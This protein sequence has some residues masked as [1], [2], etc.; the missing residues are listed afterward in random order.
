MEDKNYVVVDFETNGFQ[1]SDVLSVAA[2]KDTGEEFVRHYYPEGEYNESAIAVNGLTEEKITELRGD[3]DY[4]EHFKDDKEFVEF[5]KDADVFVAHNAAFDYSFLPDEVKEQGLE[6]VDTMKANMDIVE[7]KAPKLSEAA[8]FYGVE[9][10][11]EDLHGAKADA[12]ITKGIYEAMPE[13]RKEPNDE[14]LTKE[15]AAFNENGEQVVAFGSLRGLTANEMNEEQVDK[16]LS[17]FD[18][19]EKHEMYDQVVERQQELQNGKES[20]GNEVSES[21]EKGMSQAAEKS[22]EAVQGGMER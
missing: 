15:F 21:I 8:D 11:S 22:V 6:I 13:E 3:A 9:Y 10:N 19:P 18:S 16:F 7:G 20:W 4:A 14:Y 5:M 1:G 17:R 2:I 12:E